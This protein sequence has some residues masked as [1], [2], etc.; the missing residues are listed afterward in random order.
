MSGVNG[1]LRVDYCIKHAV[2]PQADDIL[3]AT[4][5]LFPD[6]PYFK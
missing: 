6:L 5:I 3:L 4:L 2:R 1:T